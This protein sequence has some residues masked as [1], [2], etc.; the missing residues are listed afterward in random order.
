MDVFYKELFV[1]LPRGWGVAIYNGKK[2]KN[3]KWLCTIEKIKTKKL[4]KLCTI[5]NESLRVPGVIDQ[6]SRVD[7]T[8]G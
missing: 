7:R 6:C 3:K 2:I 8:C 4:K 5:T 1:L